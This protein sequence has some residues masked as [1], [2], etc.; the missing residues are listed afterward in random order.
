MS[1]T[2][3]QIIIAGIVLLIILIFI[4]I[5]LGVVP[6]LKTVKTDPTKIKTSL[7]VWIVFDSPAN[8]AGILA[9]FK[10]IY[11]NVTI[12]FRV[13]NDEE[14]YENALLNALAEGQGPDIFMIRN[15]ALLKNKNKLYPAP[16]IKLSLIN[17][18][19]L[20]AQV[21]E[22]DF[23]DQNK[24]Y[25]LPLAIDTL[26]MFYNRGIFNQAGIIT[27]PV[28]WEEFQEIVRQLTK[29]DANRQI[30]FSGAAIG[31]SNQTIATAGD[32]LHLLMLQKQIPMPNFNSTNGVQALNFYT[33]FAN[34]ASPFYAWNENQPNYLTAFS[35]EKT[36]IIF[37]Y[38]STLQTIKKLNPSLNFNV[39][40]I[41]QFQNQKLAVTYPTY[42]GYGVNRQSKKISLAWDF[43]LTMT[44]KPTVAETYLK[45]AGKPAALNS[46]ISKQMNDPEMNIFA[47]QTLIAKSWPQVNPL[48][49]SEI[50][51]D[52]IANVIIGRLTP[53]QA[54]EQAK[55]RVEKFIK[56]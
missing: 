26:A 54:L 18:R 49:I 11:P 8:Y 5:I 28:I 48:A 47:K 39:A 51:S 35:N 43:I 4:L 37:D 32:L 52:A 42:W 29:L 10:E 34:A 25:A 27:P 3:N 16:E 17:F 33:Q 6:G 13:F 24:I 30:I 1:L 14:E 50:L 46:L 55:N 22:T 44:T 19:N 41:P 56:Q 12:N 9:A 40:P 36:A 53:Q 21:V 45:T 15:G 7:N 38:A 23:V 2:K 20:F 31:G